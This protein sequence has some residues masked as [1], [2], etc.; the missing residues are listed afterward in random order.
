M[1][2][3]WPFEATHEKLHLF[4]TITRVGLV[5]VAP[6]PERLVY[7]ILLEDVH[8]CSSGVS[9]SF[10]SQQ[11]VYRA[12]NIS[13]SPLFLRPAQRCAFSNIYRGDSSTL[14]EKYVEEIT[15]NG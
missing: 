9:H 3:L 7:T 13:C 4:L 15:P 5:V 14:L 12:V 1:L 6:V 2:Q 11:R 8:V 10:T